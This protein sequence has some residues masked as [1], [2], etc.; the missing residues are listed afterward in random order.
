MDLPANS[1]HCVGWNSPVL[2]LPAG[3]ASIVFAPAK[4]ANQDQP[5]VSATEIGAIVTNSLKAVQLV[6]RVTAFWLP[7]FLLGLTFTPLAHAQEKGQKQGSVT[8]GVALRAFVDES[9]SGWAGNGPRP[10]ATI[11]WYPA[12]T[13]SKLKAPNL[14]A[15][16]LQQF[17]VSYPLAENAAIPGQ[18][19]KYPLV[20]LSH[21]NTSSALSLNWFGYYLA[22]HGYVVA[23]VNHH[24]NT[25]AEPGGPLP[26]GFG[27]QWE[28]AKDLSALI[29]KMLGDPFF[30]PHIDADRIAAAGHSSG[31]A[32]VL[33]LAGAIFDPDRIQAFCN[34]NKVDDP[35]C[36]PPPMIRDQIK[37]FAAL[38]ET[39]PV[40]QASV[41]RSH[42]PYNDPRVKAVFAM[43]PAIGV[44]HTDASL[45]AI[46]IPVYIVAGRADNITPLATNAERFAD[47]IPTATLTI[48]PG[49]VGHATFGSLCTPAGL[50]ATDWVNWVCH[51]EEGVDRALVHEQVERIALSFFQSALASK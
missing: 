22:S 20:V 40:V 51:D 24:G 37:Q 25:A 16:E 26:Q 8:V 2:L 41:K 12:A 31:G 9:R 43:T 10:L 15:P 1:A 32:T 47:L 21:G 13:G 30:G 19:E 36:D 17:F 29:D 14:G 42:F 34:S 23:A 39:D 28:R 46:R 44:G 11:I 38:K 4:Q 3:L 49:M 35:N 7:L 6:V 33:E 45:R 18:K 5:S 27:A 48:L 50:K